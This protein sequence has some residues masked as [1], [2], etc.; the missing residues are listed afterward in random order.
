MVN[1]RPICDRILVKRLDVEEVSPGGILIPAD[2]QEKPM[3]GRVIA[4]GDGMRPNGK[5]VP[6]DIQPGDIIL[7]GNYAGVEVKISNEKFIV[8]KEADV[9]GVLE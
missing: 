6:L 8:M 1:F 9:M 4:V 3:Q 2:A 5:I 7:F